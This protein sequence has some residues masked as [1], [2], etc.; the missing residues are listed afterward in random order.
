M[1]D[2]AVVEV[3]AVHEGWSPQSILQLVAD[4]RPAYSALIDVGALITGLSNEQVARALLDRGLPFE[5]VVFLD[6]GGEQRLLQRGRPDP[7]KLA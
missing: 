2:P 7:L 6:A 5:A 3:R 4:A 1:I